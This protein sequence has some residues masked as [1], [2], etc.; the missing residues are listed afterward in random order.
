MSGSRVH[1]KIVILSL[2]LSLGRGLGWGQSTDRGTKET[3]PLLVQQI[4][5]LQKQTGDLQEKVKA[6]EAAKVQDASPPETAAAATEP[7][8]QASSAMDALEAWHKTH[9]IQWRG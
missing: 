4:K 2:L 3:I 8:R 9:G 6:L 1:P 5:D 7:S